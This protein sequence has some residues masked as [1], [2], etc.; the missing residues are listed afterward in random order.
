MKSTLAILSVLLCLVSW[1]GCVTS[2]TGGTGPLVFTAMGC[3]PYNEAAEVALRRFV[4]TENRVSD[5]EFMVHLG[6]IVTGKRLDWGEDQFVKV[7]ELLTSGNSIPTFIVP[8][9]NEWN[10]QNDPAQSWIWWTNHFLMMDAR[11][12]F[13]SPVARQSGRWENCAFVRNGALVIGI[14]KVGGKIHDPAE[15]DARLADNAK[16][17]SAQFEEHGAK[18]HSAVILAQA[19]A[20]GGHTGMLKGFTNAAKAFGQPVLYLH[21]DGHKWY[22]NEKEWAPNITHVQLDLISSNFPP[23]Q[24]TLTGDPKEPFRFDRRLDSSVWE[25]K[26]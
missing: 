18:V 1:S 13:P 14:N 25:T 8:G 19:T 4:A 11:W 20:A 3:G 17:I 23:V 5:S 21:A 2:N 15:W 22:V 16:W 6:D 26:R 9:D 12:D 7:H 10:D 24:V